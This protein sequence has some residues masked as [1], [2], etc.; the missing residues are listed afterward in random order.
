MR[1][2][3]PQAV[4]VVDSA[5]D[6]EEDP[7]DDIDPQ[8]IQKNL[9]AVGIAD[10]KVVDPEALDNS[11][12][13][14]QVMEDVQNIESLPVPSA[15]PRPVERRL[16]VLHPEIST[17]S[18]TNYHIRTNDLGAGVPIERFYHNVHAI[19]CMRT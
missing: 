1:G 4:E 17:D 2:Y 7:F 8:Q 18:R 5:P 19:H 16:H 3:H 10:G 12:F 13:I 11:P 9:E 6:V 14:R 15:V